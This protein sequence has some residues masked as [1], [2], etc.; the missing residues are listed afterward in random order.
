[1]AR[2]SRDVVYADTG[3]AG[4][5]G[6]T[7][8]DASGRVLGATR[9]VVNAGHPRESDLRLNT[10][11]ENVLATASGVDV[12]APRQERVDLW[13]LLALLALGVIVAEW[14]MALWPVRRGAVRR[15]ARGSAG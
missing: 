13:P 4:T 14:I 9:F 11:L 2:V 15:P 12:A 7:E 1:R 3:S 6:V 8:R 5:Y 10:D